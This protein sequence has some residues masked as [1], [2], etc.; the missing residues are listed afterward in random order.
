[1]AKTAGPATTST[2]TTNPAVT[3]KTT[4]VTTTKLTNPK[5]VI[6]TTT[7]ASQLKT[8]RDKPR[9]ITSKTTTTTAVVASI[10]TTNVVTSVSTQQRMKTP[11]QHSANK[12]QQQAV[13]QQH[14]ATSKNQ[15]L[16][17]HPTLKHQNH[18][19]Q[20]PQYLLHS[21]Q[22]RPEQLQL[23]QLQQQ[24]QQ[25]QLH[26]LQQQQQFNQLRHN[27]PRFY[28][29]SSVKTTKSPS[30]ILSNPSLTPIGTNPILTSRVSWDTSLM[31]LSQSL[32]NIC[33]SPLM[34]SISSTDSSPLPKKLPSRHSLQNQKLYQKPIAKVVT[35]LGNPSLKQ[36]YQT[37]IPSPDTNLST[38]YHK[39]LDLTDRNKSIDLK[40]SEYRLD[41]PADNVFLSNCDIVENKSAEDSVELIALPSEFVN[42]IDTWK[43]EK[44]EEVRMNEMKVEMKIDALVVSTEA[45]RESSLKR[46]DFI[47]PILP[48]R[49]RCNTMNAP[50][51]LTMKRMNSAAIMFTPTQ[52]IHFCDPNHKKLIIRHEETNQLLNFEL[53]KLLQTNLTQ[54]SNNRKDSEHSPD[55]KG[56][57]S[58]SSS[59]LSSHRFLYKVSLKSVYFPLEDIYVEL[60][61]ERLLRVAI[62]K[63]KI[64]STR[65]RGHSFE[66]VKSKQ[67]SSILLEDVTL[68]NELRNW[69]CFISEDRRWLIVKED[70]NLTDFEQE[71]FSYPQQTGFDLI[72]KL[73]RSPT[74]KFTSRSI[75]FTMNYNESCSSKYVPILTSQE[76]SNQLNI[77]LK[78]PDEFDHKDISIKR[79]DK[80]L[81][82]N[83]STEKLNASIAMNSSA[84]DTRDNNCDAISLLQISTNYNDS[85]MHPNNDCTDNTVNNKDSEDVPNNTER[86]D[87]L[88]SLPAFQVTI[89]LPTNVHGRTL[90][91][92]LT[93]KNV[94]IIYGD[95]DTSRRRNSF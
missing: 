15:H 11:Q 32:K 28:R 57:C 38:T 64:S 46:N 93:K 73:A 75:T 66:K 21:Q 19:Q 95:A 5:T 67:Y 43:C 3:T 83:G 14:F 1:M 85:N 41:D 74:K 9:A 80:M 8:S 4:N 34:R 52:N 25:L 31:V 68:P 37:S 55:N 23:H 40:L 65:D 48:S 78:V 76:P 82:I 10:T 20:Q 16:H 59:L 61:N 47:S 84:V 60:I 12:Q 54:R 87:G 72:E 29:Q 35:Q 88:T 42:S 94:I 36:Y 50:K 56:E 69:I 89:N 71:H 77:C 33:G 27:T 24:Q 86:D 17:S 92:Y 79:L 62:M 39:S 53:T 18:L 49:D 7:T 81:V 2:K 26:Q 30:A 90:S 44:D 45:C 22:Q 58:L 91:A 51:R 6:L 63:D 13:K 70:S